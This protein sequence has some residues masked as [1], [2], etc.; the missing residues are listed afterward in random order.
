[1]FISKLRKYLSVP[2]N[3]SAIQ[4]ARRKHSSTGTKLN[5]IDAIFMSIQR[6]KAHL[7]KLNFLIFL[8]FLIVSIIIIISAPYFN[9]LVA[10][11]YKN[12]QQFKKLL[13]TEISSL[14]IKEN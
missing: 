2:Y 10:I 13:P 7:S 8:S 6:T 12:N 1:M 3:S 14:N 5:M 4:R 11:I 9:K